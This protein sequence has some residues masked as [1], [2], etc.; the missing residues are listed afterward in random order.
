MNTVYN[1][2]IRG[3][4]YRLL[5]L[6]NNETKITVRTTAGDTEEAFTGENI[7][8]G[9]NEGAIIS[10]A[11]IDYT[12]QNY[13]GD[14]KDELSYTN[15]RLQPLIF[16]D[17]ILRLSKNV[18]EA[19]S[20]NVKLEKVAETK[21]LDFNVEKSSFMIFGSKKG[22]TKIFEQLHSNPLTLCGKELKLSDHERYLGDYLSSGGLS[23]S[24]KTTIAKRKGFV[25]SNI[26]NIRNIIEDCRANIAGGIIAGIEI[27]ELAII[28]YLFALCSK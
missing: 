6:L 4:L 19:Q 9:T 17:D 11:N 14:S 3:K 5:F 8:Q 1:S 16:Q 7:G 15:L 27:W 10:A 12:M 21:L 23:E 20:G 2:G 18:W 13:F 24:V 28:P 22:K 25:I 26:Y